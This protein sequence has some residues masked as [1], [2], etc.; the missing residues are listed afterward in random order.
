MINKKAMKDAKSRRCSCDYRIALARD[1]LEIS[2]RRGYWCHASAT[3]NKTETAEEL[4]SGPYRI[5]SRVQYRIRSRIR[6]HPC[7]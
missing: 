7:L 3:S 4:A 6:K 1:V 5:G 2:M